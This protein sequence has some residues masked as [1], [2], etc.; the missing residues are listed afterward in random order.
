MQ[1]RV[2]YTADVEADSVP[3]AVQAAI[4]QAASGDQHFRLLNLDTRENIGG[5]TTQQVA[6]ASSMVA[7]NTDE[8]AAGPL[9]DGT[10]ITITTEDEVAR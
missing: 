10:T 2:K 6:P 9:H 8:R 7:T 1:Y 4:A 3:D 5:H